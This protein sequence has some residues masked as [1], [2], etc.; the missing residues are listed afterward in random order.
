MECNEKSPSFI[1]GPEM[2]R[3]QA[4]LK[5]MAVY[6]PHVQSFPPFSFALSAFALRPNPPSNSDI[7]FGVGRFGEMPDHQEGVR[8]KA[9]RS[10]N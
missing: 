8:C 2:R 10:D 9:P 7:T 5:G 6:R 1:N 3:R 4:K